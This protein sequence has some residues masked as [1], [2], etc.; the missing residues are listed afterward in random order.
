MKVTTSCSGRFWVF[1]Q[2]RELHR[3]KVL[4]KLINDYPTFVTRQWGIPDEKVISLIANGVL[5]RFARFTGRYLPSSLHNNYVQTV[6]TLFSRR[7]ARYLPAES[8]VF[9]GLSSF[10]LEAIEKAKDLG[11]MTIVDHG[12][13]HQRVER[14]LMEEESERFS[15][16]MPDQMASD[17][18][19]RKEDEEFLLADRVMVLSEAAKKSL[20]SEGI[21]SN[22]ILVNPCGV[23]V[24]AFKPG[25]KE[26]DIFRIMFC[27]ASSPRKG[28]WY[29][30][31]AFSDLNLP[32]SELWIVGSLP[33]SEFRKLLAPLILPNVIF[34]GPV[35]Q[36]RLQDYYSQSSV[37][38]LPSIADGFGMVVLQAMACGLPVI[39]SEN[40]GAA[41]IISHGIDGFIVPI[42]GVDALK[43]VI[44]KLY[45]DPECLSAMSMA[46]KTK[47]R[48]SISWNSYGE[49]LL[50]GMEMLLQ[51]KALSCSETL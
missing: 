33:S 48:S 8:D 18:I 49:R 38:V 35:S 46:V 43:E 14:R 21:P 30:L 41:D 22:K 2:A 19:I 25:E 27:G 20:V 4:Y 1:D 37:F 11:I 26:D 16:A 47:D 39:V 32:Q 29:L 45:E 40:V 36:S 42:R 7:L 9:I 5:A 44:L 23:G 10:C 17:W 13:F 34:K 12:S 31:K 15:I 24:E 50:E 51:S 6:H 28:L 3:L